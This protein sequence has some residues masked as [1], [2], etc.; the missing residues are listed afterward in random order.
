M[1]RPVVELPDA[2]PVT[3]LGRGVI[4]GP[5]ARAPEPWSAAERVV[6]DDSV[7]AD[8]AVVVES[9]HRHWSQRIPV[10]VELQCS[11]DELRA[12]EIEP[13]RA[14]Y[15]LSPRFEFG[16][17]RLYFLTRANNYDD[18]VGRMVWGPAVEAQRLGA[19]AAAGS[20]V[21]LADGTPA[22]CDG[23]PRTGTP[24]V[25]DGHV[26]VHRNNLEQRVLI[27]DRSVTS[28]AE[29]AADQLA[30]VV[31]D[32]GA[33]RVIA[34]AGS[35][36]TR[37]LTERFRLLVDRGWSPGSITA[38]AYNVRAKDTM[39]DRLADMP[40]GARRRVR[41]LHAL[42]ND[43]LGRGGGNGALID[44]WEMRRRIEALVPVK[45][46]ANTDTYAPYLEALSEVRLGL[47]DPNVVEAQR[48]DVAGFGAMFEEYR[49][50]LHA[51]RAIDH[52]EQ[53]YGAIEVLLR[54]PE[55]RG[56][57][58][59]EA[60]HLLVDEFQDLTPAQ[61]LLLRLV[62]APAYDVFGVGDDDQVIY[63]YAGADPE[64]LINYDRYFPGGTHHALA[65]N[66]RCPEAVV[67]ATRNLLSYNRRRIDKEIIAAK[68]GGDADDRADAQNDAQA[69]AMSIVTTDPERVAG[70][71]VERV[72]A[73]LEAGAQPC[74]IAV[75][76]RVNSVLL[77][78]QLLLGEAG[79]PSWTPVSVA[80]LNR[81]GTRTALAYLRLALA[82]GNNT[83]FH[84]ADLAL[85][86]RRPSRSLRREVLQ[87]LERK[88]AWTMGQLRREPDAL[89]GTAAAKFDAFCD[90][91]DAL[92]RA[93]DGGATTARLLTL[94][95]DDV[96]LGAALATLDL[97]GK[98]PDASHRDDLNALISVATF[99]PDPA[100]FEPWLRDRLRAP[101]ERAASE[102]VALSTVHRVKG[103]EWPY[104]VV[105]GAH[106]GLMPHALADD[107]EEERRI[108]HV[109]ITRGD[110]AVQ[111]IA[112]ATAR[113]PFLDELLAPAPARPERVARTQV[114]TAEAQPS[115]VR[116]TI[117]A[118]LGLEVEFAGSSGALVELRVD[119]AVLEEPSGTRVVIPYGERVE[120][121]GRRAQLVRGRTADVTHASPALV[122][123]LKAWRKQRAAGDRVPA[124][125]VLSDAHL[126]GIADRRPESLADLAG[127]TGIG[128]TKLERYGDEIIAVIADSSAD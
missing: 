88:R 98:A 5:G 74:E 89:T 95:R 96:G 82:A 112:D 12:P 53:I 123:A 47:V 69:D 67:T 108:F 33:A 76:S 62:A 49:D 50:K 60:R 10:V 70:A 61:L 2:E 104:V 52:D 116:N 100:S 103:M 11:A 8:P 14:P 128:P 51:D 25:P 102:G 94:I 15:E 30:A 81:T 35:G 113:R 109:A 110:T 99:E 48:D 41:T 6:L 63:G 22:W 75:L 106:D 65:T 42:G 40:E 27:A 4:V 85:A 56:A 16:R 9:L 101:N 114:T 1:M 17:E 90:D 126:E 34:P 71:A 46:R 83:G 92:G 20:D 84:G 28:S 122:E 64:F 125:I 44:E 39:R 24:S 43:V 21:V 105:L 78:A 13:A 31:H 80:V 73:W 38:V 124:Y 32:A 87:R 59:R 3:R 86:A 117:G 111:V 45:P 58:Q 37:V 19:V 93:F 119:G 57:F 23:G 127:C 55:V 36:K 121:D 66:Y 107:V 77:P 29:L 97:S 115:R 26:L 79:V 18:R 120:L 91:L 7:L 72:T 118:E 68:S 54:M